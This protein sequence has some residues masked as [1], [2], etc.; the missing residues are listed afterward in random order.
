VVRSPRKD[1]RSIDSTR[2]DLR[3]AHPYSPITTWSNHIL[4]ISLVL[5]RNGK[6][7]ELR[8]PPQQLL[9][10][11]DENGVLVLHSL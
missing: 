1:P 4:A 7:Q 8:L 2:V 10:R 6:R 9:L 3:G 11:S 5:R